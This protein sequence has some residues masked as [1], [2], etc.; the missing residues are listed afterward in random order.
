MNNDKDHMNE[1]NDLRILARPYVK[2][3]LQG[4]PVDPDLIT[5]ALGVSPA[6]R[7][8][9]GDTYGKKGN[10]WTI[11]FWSIS[12]RDMVESSDLENHIVW[13]LE[14]LEPVKDKLT[15]FVLQEGVDAS[16]KI[17]FNL[18]VHEWDG[19]VSANLMKRITDLNAHF[20]ISIY[21]LEDL[22]ERMSGEKPW[23]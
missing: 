23:N 5:E 10:K 18:F 17:V 19:H 15:Y 12:S 1:N 11:G 4:E 22:N 16:I 21:Y 3:I 7:F 2:F 9:K 13:I 20:K 14:R 6:R 8:K